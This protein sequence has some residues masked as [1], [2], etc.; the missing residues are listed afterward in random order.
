VP[1]S[2]ALIVNFPSKSVVVP[3]TVPVIIIEAPGKASPEVA[4]ITVPVI[5]F[6]CACNCMTNR[7]PMKDKR[8]VLVIIFIF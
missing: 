4:S 6:S 2:E 5:T 7:S 8:I 3:I 1:P